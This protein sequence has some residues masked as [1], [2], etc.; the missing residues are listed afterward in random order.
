ML[1]G[2]RSHW[3]AINL[4]T[5][6]IILGP[7]KRCRQQVFQVLFNPCLVHLGPKVLASRFW[8]SIQPYR[9]LKL[10]RRVGF[11]SWDST[12]SPVSRLRVVNCLLIFPC[13]HFFPY[14]YKKNFT[15]ASPLCGLMHFK[16]VSLIS[17]KWMR[18]FEKCASSYPC[19]GRQCKVQ[20]CVP[21]GWPSPKLAGKQSFHMVSRAKSQYFL[22]TGINRQ[23]PMQCTQ[24]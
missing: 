21:G 1:L 7:C 3:Q 19:S 13:W 8:T 2:A 14:N 15:T 6:P 22:I 9:V 16:P 11:K 10:C 23:C 12:W 4:S 20:I 18:K 24:L 5:G 17:I